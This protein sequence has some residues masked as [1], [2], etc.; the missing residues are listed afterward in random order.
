MALGGGTALE[1]VASTFSLVAH[2]PGA[3]VSAPP[4]FAE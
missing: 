1:S 2:I 4:P 3:E